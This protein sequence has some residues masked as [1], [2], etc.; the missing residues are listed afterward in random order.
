M[1]PTCSAKA[2]ARVQ[3]LALV[4]A[5]TKNLDMLEGGKSREAS[6]APEGDIP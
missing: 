3:G 4:N 6:K 5:P 2:T 1:T